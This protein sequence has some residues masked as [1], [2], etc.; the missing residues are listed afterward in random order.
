MLE[1]D[2]IIPENDAST[3]RIYGEMAMTDGQIP[4]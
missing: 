1:K 4:K 2:T 3:T